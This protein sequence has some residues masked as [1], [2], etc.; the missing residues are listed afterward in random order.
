MLVELLKDSMSVA[1]LLTQ[2]EKSV[3]GFHHDTL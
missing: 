1:Y 2:E 3:Y